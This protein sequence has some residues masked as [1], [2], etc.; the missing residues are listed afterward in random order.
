MNIT[1][2]FDKPLDQIDNEML[3]AL[4]M[5]TRFTTNFNIVLNEL[6]RR[7]GRRS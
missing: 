5:V 6:N 7:Y 1:F 2:T 4:L 3:F